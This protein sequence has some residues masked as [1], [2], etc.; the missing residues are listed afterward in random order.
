MDLHGLRPHLLS[1]AQHSSFLFASAG[2]EEWIFKAS[3]PCSVIFP[4]SHVNL[5]QAV[6]SFKC[7]NIVCSPSSV[8]EAWRTLEGIDQ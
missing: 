7:E 1:C 3:W 4:D 5:G 6:C 8:A 2:V